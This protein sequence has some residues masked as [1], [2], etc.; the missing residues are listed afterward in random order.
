MEWV[1]WVPP[2][3]L[4]AFAIAWHTW[5]YGWRSSTRTLMLVAFAILAGVVVQRLVFAD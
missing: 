3:L 5:T 2:V 1:Y 4:F